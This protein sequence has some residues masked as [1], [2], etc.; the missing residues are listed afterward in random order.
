MSRFIKKTS[1]PLTLVALLVAALFTLRGEAQ[2]PKTSNVATGGAVDKP[3]SG[4]AVAFAESDAVRDLPDATAEEIM[5]F[6]DAREINE[7]N[8][9]PYKKLNPEAAYSKCPALDT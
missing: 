5:S 9:I 8:V 6:G 2:Q 3:I 4:S 7:D 1:L